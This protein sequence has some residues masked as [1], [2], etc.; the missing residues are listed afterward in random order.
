MAGTRV[1]VGG[2]SISH[3]DRELFGEAHLTKRDLAAYDEQ[4]ADWMVPHVAGWI[5]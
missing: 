1:E 5:I 4:V 3:P 2:V